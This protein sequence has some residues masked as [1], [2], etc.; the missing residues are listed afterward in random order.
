MRIAAKQFGE[1]VDQAGLYFVESYGAIEEFFERGGFAVSYAA[2]NDQVEI[3]KIGGDVEG[4][5]VRSDP[6]ADVDADGGEF[7]FAREWRR[8]RFRFCREC[9]KR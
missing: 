7:F 2:R 3:A 1:M 5:A 9:D 6:A 4:K 8:P